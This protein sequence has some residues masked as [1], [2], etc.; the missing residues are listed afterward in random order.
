VARV[1]AAIEQGSAVN[2][3]GTVVTRRLDGGLVNEQGNV[4]YPIRND[5]PCLLADEAIVLA[6]FLN[7]QSAEP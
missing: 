6:P 7:S 2:R 1:N 5:I 3:V 4:L